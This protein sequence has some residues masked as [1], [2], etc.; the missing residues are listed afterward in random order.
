[1]SYHNGAVLVAQTDIRFFTFLPLSARKALSYGEKI[2]K[3]GPVYPEILD[4]ICQF[5]AVSYLTYANKPCHLWSY[6]AKFTKFLDDV[7]PSS[8]LLTRTA[9]Q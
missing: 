3:I 6:Q 1:M 8:S 7:D 2:A 4:Y 9:K 5:F